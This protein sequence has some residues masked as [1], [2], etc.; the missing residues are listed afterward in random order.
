MNIDKVIGLKFLEESG[1]KYR[2]ETSYYKTNGAKV[3]KQQ[4][5]MLYCHILP[6]ENEATIYLSMLIIPYS[7]LIVETL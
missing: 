1:K 4:R 6:S 3:L 7:F 5:P 2:D